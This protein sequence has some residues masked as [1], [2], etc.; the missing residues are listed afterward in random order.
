MDF[1]ENPIAPIDKAA[2]KVYF[3]IKSFEKK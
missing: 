2:E 3:I 1:R